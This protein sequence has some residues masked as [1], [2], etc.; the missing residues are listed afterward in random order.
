VT[1]PV[2]ALFCLTRHGQ[3]CVVGLYHRKKRSHTW[4]GARHS[5]EILVRKSLRIE[6]DAT[7]WKY[8][9]SNSNCAIKNSICTTWRCD[10]LRYFTQIHFAF[11]L[12]FVIAYRRFIDLT[13]D[14]Q[15]V[16]YLQW[17]KWYILKI[18]KE[19]TSKIG[20]RKLKI[21]FA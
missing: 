7:T 16:C 8:Y 17:S 20:N 14:F 3:L 15:D 6:R 21:V 5:T 10:F 13:K 1:K 2:V 18:F 4:N 11:G 19:K 12:L 9:T